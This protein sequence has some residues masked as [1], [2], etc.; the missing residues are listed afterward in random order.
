MAFK[1]IAFSSKPASVL[2][3][4]SPRSIGLR[5]R[6]ESRRR[7]SVT[8]ES[9]SSASSAARGLHRLARYAAAMTFIL[10]FVGGLVTST[11]SGLAVPDWPLAFGRLVPPHWIGGIRFEYSHR[12]M[13]GTVAILTLALAGWAWFA[14]RRR[15]VRGLALAAFGLVVAQALLGAL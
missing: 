8:E 15:W 2:I 5:I 6:P 7:E 12:V 1:S 4:C 13:A 10:I 3:S 14:E 9:F 11:G